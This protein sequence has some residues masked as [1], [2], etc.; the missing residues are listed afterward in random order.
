MRLTE[1][2]ND[3]AEFRQLEPQ[4]HLPPQ[5]TAFAAIGLRFPAALAGHHQ[6][7]FGVLRLSRAQKA[8][9]R[10]VRLPL[11]HAVQVDA[12]VD[13]IAAARDALF[14]PAVERR[15]RRRFDRWRR[16]GPCGVLR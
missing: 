16:L 3:V 4:W 8:E 15:K 9:Q 5:H 7:D 13:S 2:D 11:C 14:E 12:R 6:H 10:N 1:A